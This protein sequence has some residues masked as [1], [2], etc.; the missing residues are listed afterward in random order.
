MSIDQIVE[1]IGKVFGAMMTPPF[2]AL[3]GS[4]VATQA[5]KTLDHRLWREMRRGETWLVAYVLTQVFCAIACWMQ[6]V[7][8]LG[9]NATLGLV[10]GFGG[11]LATWMLK[12]YLGVDIDEMFRGREEE[13]PA[14]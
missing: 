14:A 2:L 11:P 3:I 5:A 12:K 8:W 13:P 1:L 6:N 4:I 9:T 7:P 10:A